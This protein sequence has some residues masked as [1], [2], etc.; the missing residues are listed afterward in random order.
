[1]RSCRTSG[2]SSIP[3]AYSFVRVASISSLR[4]ATPRLTLKVKP[5]AAWAYFMGSAETDVGK[6]IAIRSRNKPI[7]VTCFMISHTPEKARHP[8]IGARH[9]GGDKDTK[10]Q[11]A[12]CI[13]QDGP[14]HSVTAMWSLTT[15]EAGLPYTS[16]FQGATDC[17]YTFSSSCRISVH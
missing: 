15:P 13:G 2:N 3:R 9:Q 10:R 5:L 7:H 8:A 17:P 4:R 11:M 6:S 12:E 16:R 14:I 1:M